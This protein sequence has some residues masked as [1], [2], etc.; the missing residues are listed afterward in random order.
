VVTDDGIVIDCNPLPQNA[1]SS[2]R[3]SFEPVSNEISES[4]LHLEKHD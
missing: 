1:D 3:S 4:D 2:M